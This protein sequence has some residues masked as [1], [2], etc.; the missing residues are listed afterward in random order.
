MTGPDQP[1]TRT[2]GTDE[3]IAVATAL[4][5]KQRHIL[6]LI[7]QL[8]HRIDQ[9]QTSLIPVQQQREHRYT[10]QQQRRSDHHQYDNNHEDINNNETQLQKQSHQLHES[11]STSAASKP[12]LS[13]KLPLTAPWGAETHLY[14]ADNSDAEVKALIQH[15]T[16]LCI[17]VGLTQ[18]QF[19]QVR[20]DYYELPLEERRA[21][22][23]APSVDHLCKTIV[24]ENTKCHSDSQEAFHHSS[25]IAAH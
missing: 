6:D 7:H 18:F 22:L 12:S 5:Q 21:V 17:R 10:S 3:Y 11:Q 13:S 9:I 24:M 15:L 16:E 2:S 20:S 14:T 25:Q 1:Q 8:D 4:A 19:S 23:N